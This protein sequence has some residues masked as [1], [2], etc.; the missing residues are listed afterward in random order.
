MR[1][2]F[3]ASLALALLCLAACK[4]NHDNATPTILAISPQQAAG[5]AQITIEGTG[6]PNSNQ[7]SVTINDS[8]ATIISGT[9]TALSVIV[10]KKAGSG[11]V[12]VKINGQIITGPL[13]QYDTVW[14]VSTFAGSTQGYA[15]AN[16][17]AAL[18]NYPQGICVDAQGNLYVTDPG[19]YRIRKI[20]SD[21]TVS[22]LA[23]STLGYQDGPGSSAQFG[24]PSDICRDAAGNLYVSDWG[25]N[26]IRK[27]SPNGTVGTLLGTS[28]GLNRPSGLSVD[29]QGNLYIADGQNNRILKVTPDTVVSVLAGGTQ[30]SADGTGT[31]ASFNNVIGL[32]ID[33]IGNLFAVDGAN[34]AIREITPAGVVTTVLKTFNPTEVYTD[35]RDALFFTS[36][37]DIIGEATLTGYASTLAGMYANQGYTEGFGNE[38]LFNHPYGICVDAAENIFVCDA[39]NNRIRKLVWQ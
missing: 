32:T 13:F 4:K 29:S 31:A 2:T 28:A 26:A 18:F 33:S 16:G 3:P 38:A 1:R 6:L 17:T 27:I 24:Y 37:Y 25:N 5:G 35:R 12:L 11:H 20:T 10:P 39:G 22:T 34:D 30:G 8:P 14:F 19:N 15:N 23:G 36:F 21:G 7:L 9:S